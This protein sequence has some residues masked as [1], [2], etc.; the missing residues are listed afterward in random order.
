VRLPG[1]PRV[2]ADEIDCLAQAPD[3]PPSGGR[4]LLAQLIDRRQRPSARVRAAM[5]VSPPSAE[6]IAQSDEIEKAQMSELGPRRRGACY[7]EPSHLAQRDNRRVGPMAAHTPCANERS[8]AERADVDVQEKPAHGLTGSA[9]GARRAPFGIRQRRE[10]ER[11]GPAPDGD[12]GFMAETVIGPESRRIVVGLD[13]TFGDLLRVRVQVVESGLYPPRTHAVKRCLEISAP[14]ASSAD[15]RLDGGCDAE[16][17]S[18]GFGE[19][20]WR[21]HPPTLPST[22]GRRGSYPQGVT[23]SRSQWMPSCGV[24]PASRSQWMPLTRA[25]GGIQCDLGLGGPDPTASSATWTTDGS[26]APAGNA[27]GRHADAGR[28][29]ERERTTRRGGAGRPCRRRPR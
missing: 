14:Q 6:V 19:R 2:L 27:R 21:G 18:E 13:P 8:V 16:S 15:A 4:D 24:L 11:Q 29:S 1:R 26:W 20:A 28:P 3:A 12:G 9:I 7:E 5:A 22:R 10:H 25:R 17:S 23:A